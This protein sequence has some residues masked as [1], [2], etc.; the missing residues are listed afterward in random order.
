M[1]SQLPFLQRVTPLRCFN[2][3]NWF[4]KIRR[5]NN[6]T[7]KESKPPVKEDHREE[8]L[9]KMQPLEETAE[10]PDNTNMSL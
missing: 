4:L 2:D 8:A 7:S 10:D 6:H 1:G 9:G 3:Q 5:K